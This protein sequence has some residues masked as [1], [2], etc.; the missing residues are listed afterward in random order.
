MERSAIRAMRA[1]RSVR[2]D[3]LEH[4]FRLDLEIIPAAAGPDDRAGGGGLVDA[5]LDHG[6]V[7]VNGNDLAER[8]PGIGFLAV[9]ALEPDDVG[10]LAFEG[11]RTFAYARH[12][13]EPAGH[14]GEPGDLELVDL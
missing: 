5:I 11:D 2:P 14:G 9:G 13:D 7:D 1:T 4:V 8:Q 10:H 6:L 3:H 12:V